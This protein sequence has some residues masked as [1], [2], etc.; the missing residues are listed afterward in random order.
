MSNIL[1]IFA[2]VICCVAFSFGFW[3]VTWQV[4]GGAMVFCSL[5]VTSIYLCILLIKACLRL[6]SIVV[7]TYHKNEEPLKSILAIIFIL[8]VIYFI[9]RDL[10]VKISISSI[11]DHKEVVSL[12]AIYIIYCIYKL[13]S[14]TRTQY[15]LYRRNILGNKIGFFSNGAIISDFSDFI[16]AALEIH[17]KSLIWIRKFIFRFCV[18]ASF[19]AYFFCLFD[20]WKNIYDVV[21]FI[22]F[23]IAMYSVWYAVNEHYMQEKKYTFIRYNS[24]KEE[25]RFLD[26]EE[27]NVDDEVEIEWHKY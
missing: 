25:L 17:S 22:S 13:I 12:F 2:F 4:F 10:K 6:F 18:L 7:E 16:F 9:F 23:A 19:I 26:V 11:I 1:K 15:R 24:A 3:G 8:S 27:V 14:W 20:E 21:A 5:I